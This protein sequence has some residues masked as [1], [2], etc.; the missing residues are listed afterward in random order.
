MA[1]LSAPTATQLITPT[2]SLSSSPTP[3]PEPSRLPTPNGIRPSPL[4][5]TPS[6]SSSVTPTGN[7]LTLPKTDQYNARGNLPNTIFAVSVISAVLGG[8]AA[9][10]LAFAAQ[11]FWRIVAGSWARPQLGVYIA[12]VAVFH[13]LEFFTTAGWNVQKLSVDAFLLNNGKQY[14]YA[15]AFG[16]AEYF[17]SSFFFPR[18]FNSRLSASPWLTLVTIIMVCAQV[19]RS[20]A[21]IQA[22]QSF[23]HIVKNKKHDDHVL[24]THGLYSWARHPAYTGFFYW[25]VATQLLLGNVVS[26]VGFILVLSKFFSARIV[27][28]ELWLVKFF[29]DEYIE[30]RKRVGTKLPFYFST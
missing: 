16:L 5:S 8:I 6:P 21:M 14:H 18:K 27:D 17:V 4:S 15:H 28:E 26:T 1:T 13:L 30:Y 11:P 9:A 3:S 29:G 10:A 19:I 7:G 2:P 25:A 20:L 24:V 23:S 22:A 12:A